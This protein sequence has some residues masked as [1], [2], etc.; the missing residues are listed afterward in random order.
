M[1]KFNKYSIDLLILFSLI[2]SIVF[3]IN[4]NKGIE[5]TDES[6][7]LLISLYPYDIVG[8]ANNSGILGNFLLQIVDYN[9]Y[10]FRLLGAG[11]LMF[12][13]ILLVNPISKFQSSILDFKNINKRF[14]ILIFILGTLSYY[15]NWIITPNYNLYT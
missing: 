13:S 10:Y 15:H 4:F 12:T 9:I 14:L 3:Y 8:R 7:V 6:Y 11:L 2:L 5:L 1:T